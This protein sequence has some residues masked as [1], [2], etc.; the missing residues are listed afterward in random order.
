MP[1]GK[2]LT[3]V[4]LSHTLAADLSPGDGDPLDPATYGFEYVD[5]GEEWNAVFRAV[6]RHLGGCG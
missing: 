6:A 4:R 5:G 1:P 2:C 3:G